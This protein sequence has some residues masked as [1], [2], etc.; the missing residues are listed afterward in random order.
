MW[1]FLGLLVTTC[2]NC[3]IVYYRSLNVIPEGLSY[4]VYC[5]MYTSMHQ[6]PAL[7]SKD[8]RLA[9]CG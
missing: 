2:Q 5:M 9:G 7:I 6:N 1:F 3:G 4:Y 8:S